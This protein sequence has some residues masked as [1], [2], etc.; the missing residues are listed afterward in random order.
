VPNPCA[1]LAVLAVAVAV[2]YTPEA[3]VVTPVVPVPAAVA[4]AVKGYTQLRIPWR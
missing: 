1:A 4:G 3:A 2:A